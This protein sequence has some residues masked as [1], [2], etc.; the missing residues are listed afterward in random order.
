MEHAL[1]MRGRKGGQPAL[2]MAHCQ[3]EG[4]MEAS[5][6]PGPMVGGGAQTQMPSG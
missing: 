2:G 5:G 4:G 6:I 1:P 3:D